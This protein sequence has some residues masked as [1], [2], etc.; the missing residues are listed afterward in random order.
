MKHDEKKLHEKLRWRTV[1]PEGQDGYVA[2]R[3][4]DSA[5]WTATATSQIMWQSSDEKMEEME[6]R[7]MTSLYRDTE[8]LGEE[9]CPRGRRRIISENLPRITELETYERKELLESQLA[10]EV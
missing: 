9:K 6:K 4:R 8:T 2:S 3:V 5:G 7:E 10:L 1:H